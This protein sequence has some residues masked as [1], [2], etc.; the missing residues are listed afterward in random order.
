MKTIL[1][2]VTMA[3]LPYG[4]VQIYR[5]I[6]NRDR[7][8][9]DMLF[10]QDRA[11][12][13]EQ[14]KKMA[15]ASKTLNATEIESVYEFLQKRGVNREQAFYGSM[16]E[17]SLIE[18]EKVLVKFYK[19][20]EPIYGLH[21][22]N[23]VGVSL[24]Y[25]TEVVRQIHQKSVVFSIDPNLPHRGISSPQDHVAALLCACGLQENSVI[26]A[27]YSGK[28]SISND[29]NFYTPDYD[30][31]KM[32]C[33]ECAC[34]NTLDNLK[35]IVSSAFDFAVLD[36][37]HEGSY[38]AQELETLMPMMKP[39]SI[40]MLDDV[41]PHWNEIQE[42][43]QSIHKYGLVPFAADGRVGIAVRGFVG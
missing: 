7:K 14:V 5:R 27:G 36:G 11:K 8:R 42:I 33:V 31:V 26:I 29:G 23:F 15:L 16:P 9:S 2:K 22:G 41:S 20:N 4:F 37:N 34:E 10:M 21:I 39:N 38:L 24:C 12:R 32:F 18:I 30:P 43:Y 40:I 35:R 6:K 17:K 19:G 3:L 1:K 13:I 25:I 28:K